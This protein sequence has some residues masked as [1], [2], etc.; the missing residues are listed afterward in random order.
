[1]TALTI[2]PAQ[3]TDLRVVS[4]LLRDAARW[5]HSRGWDAWPA[6]GFP[7]HRL[8][9]GLE[10]GTV[11]L[12]F[13]GDHA[14][15][16]MALDQHH[17]P[18]FTA[19]EALEAGVGELLADAWTSHRLAVVPPWRGCGLGQAML[20]WGTDRVARMG[21]T[22]QLANVNRRAV[23]LQKWYQRQGFDHLVTVTSTPRKSGSLW[24]R[25]ATRNPDV[26]GL[27]QEI[28]PL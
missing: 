13:M 4:G 23:P 28:R 2:R 19:P 18:E 5:M 3:P 6:D 27:V 21:G 11:W 8:T 17:D 24:A 16:T 22:H 9:P 26:R 14:V 25:P 1:M 12:M 7:D 20:T 10:E 15:A